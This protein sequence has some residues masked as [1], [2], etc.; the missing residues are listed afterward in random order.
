M[1]ALVTAIYGMNAIDLLNELKVGI[2]KERNNE[3]S[4]TEEE[5][6]F[7]MIL[8]YDYGIQLY[9]ANENSL[10]MFGREIE[11][12]QKLYTIEDSAKLDDINKIINSKMPDI[13][14]ETN[15]SIDEYM[16]Q[17]F[18]EHELHGSG[19]TPED[20]FSWIV[21]KDDLKRRLKEKC[22]VHLIASEG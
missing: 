1:K 21:D 14:E 3:L 4:I 11:D 9:D 8:H 16:D 20:Y 15:K 13:K 19:I 18:V 10:V 12:I 7:C 17:L 6:A 5:T 2:P 22:S